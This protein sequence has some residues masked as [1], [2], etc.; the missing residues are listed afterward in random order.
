M[1]M[2]TGA[3]ENQIALAT[4]MWTAEFLDRHLISLLDELPAMTVVAIVRASEL[5]SGRELPQPVVQC[6]NEARAKLPKWQERLRRAPADGGIAEAERLGFRLLAPGDRGWP[7][8]LS[9]LGP[10]RPCALWVRGADLPP[11]EAAVAIDGSRAPTAY[12]TRVAQD[13]A[14][15]LAASGTTVISGCA[16]GTGTAVHQAALMAGGATVAIVPSGPGKPFPPGNAS[17][18]EEIAARGGSIVT[19]QPPGFRP[20]RMSFSHRCRLI[21]ALS[22]GSVITEAIEP[23]GHLRTVQDAR[24]LGRAVMAVPGPVDSPQSRGCHHLIRDGAMLVTSASD[25]RKAI[26]AHRRCPVSRQFDRDEIECLVRTAAEAVH[27]N[28]V[29]DDGLSER[30]LDLSLRAYRY[31]MADVQV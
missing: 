10:G 20:T 19:E 27:G 24:Q 8:A 16:Y 25:V 7:A 13:I 9:D 2:S 28:A 29:S 17:L 1:T 14:G 15:H 26:A 11:L 30:Q 22:S 18:L 5:P 21:A 12:G 23:V 6:F 31:H 3:R 4:L